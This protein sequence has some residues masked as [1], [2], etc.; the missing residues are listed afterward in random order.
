MSDLCD[1]GLSKAF[2]DMLFPKAKVTKENIGGFDFTKNKN[3]L[4]QM[5]PSRK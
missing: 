4:L 2:L 5:M 1:L 3:V